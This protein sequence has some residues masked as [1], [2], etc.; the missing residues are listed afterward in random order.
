MLKAWAE[1]TLQVMQSLP[2]PRAYSYF[3]VQEA[4]Q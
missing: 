4:T 2:L 3:S 1:E